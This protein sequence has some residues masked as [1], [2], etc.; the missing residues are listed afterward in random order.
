MPTPRAG[1]VDDL[2]HNFITNNQQP[3]KLVRSST[4]KSAE[5]ES[6]TN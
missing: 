6:F 1:N 4:N 2:Y 5:V 3:N